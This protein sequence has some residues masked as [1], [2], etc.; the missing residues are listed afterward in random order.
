MPFPLIISLLFV[1]LPISALA[2]TASRGAE[3]YRAQCIECHGE[4]GEGSEFEEVDALYGD[5]S[6]ASLAKI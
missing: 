1:L 3:I 4:T 2:E 6:V 5:R